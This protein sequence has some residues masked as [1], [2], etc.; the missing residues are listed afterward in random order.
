MWIAK[1][2]SNETNET[3]SY[4]FILL[5]S[6]RS[7]ERID[8]TIMCVFLFFVFVSVYST[9]SRNNAPHSNL[10][11]VS[12]VKVNILG[13]LYRWSKKNKKKNYGKA[14]IFMQ[15]QFSTKSIFLYSCNSKTNH[16]K[17]L[18][19]SPNLFIDIEIFVS[20]KKFWMTEKT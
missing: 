16:Y 2:L 10:G 6:E 3:I 12:N 15:N 5:N 19:F 13:A 18:K 7:D 8:F 20:I 14:G 4:N 9:T 1:Y 17:Y 11:V